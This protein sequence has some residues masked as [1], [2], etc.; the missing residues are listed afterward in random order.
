[1]HQSHTHP[2][3][4]ENLQRLFLVLYSPK[5][6]SSARPAIT[7][8]QYLF[9]TINNVNYHKNMLHYMYEYGCWNWG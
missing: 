2:F 3:Q 9:L 4:Q 1:M 7:N 8:I 5:Q 6:L